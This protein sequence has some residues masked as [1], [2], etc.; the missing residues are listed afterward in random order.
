[1]RFGKKL[2]IIC[3]PCTVAFVLMMTVFFPI[4]NRF[5][6]GGLVHADPL[7]GTED[8][9]IAVSGLSFEDV[10]VEWLE[11]GDSGWGGAEVDA[12]RL[13]NNYTD[14]TLSSWDLF[15]P[16]CFPVDGSNTLVQYRFEDWWGG[17]AARLQYNLQYS[18]SYNY[19]S[20]DLNTLLSNDLPSG[21][22]AVVFV[23]YNGSNYQVLSLIHI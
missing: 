19:G 8:D 10:N 4:V 15:V 21:G 16:D 13:T 2:V 7:G 5:E 23:P 3:G 17:D 1:M 9:G 18:D 20:S 6:H 11:T 14:I 22:E 12:V